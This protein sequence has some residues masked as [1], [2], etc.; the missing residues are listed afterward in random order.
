MMLTAARLND[1]NAA[2]CPCGQI[3]GALPLALA[4]V[5]A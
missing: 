1:D 2:F 4:R 5:A 3:S